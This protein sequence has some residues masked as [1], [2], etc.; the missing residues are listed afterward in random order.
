MKILDDGSTA[1]VRANCS[2]VTYDVI[3]GDDTS[4]IRG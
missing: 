2:Q 4:S 3:A 1:K